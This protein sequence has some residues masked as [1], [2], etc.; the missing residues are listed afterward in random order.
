MD[1]KQLAGDL[2]LHANDER[3]TKTEAKIEAALHEAYR[4]GFLDGEASVNA[5]LA[6]DI[7][8]VQDEVEAAGVEF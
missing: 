5:A 7:Q 3:W 2:V 4:V 8:A 1:F 6:A